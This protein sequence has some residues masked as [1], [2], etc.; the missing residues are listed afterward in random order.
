MSHRWLAEAG[1]N[2]DLSPDDLAALGLDTD[3]ADQASA[4]RWLTDRF[5]E[6]VDVG[7]TQVSL[8]EG[9]R[10]IYGPMSLLAD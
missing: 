7:I 8:F 1:A 5:E 9:D 2:P 6:L 10:L 4:E 3:F